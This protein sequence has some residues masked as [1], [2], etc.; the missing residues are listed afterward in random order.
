MSLTIRANAQNLE[1][2]KAEKEGSAGNKKTINAANLN[3][4]SGKEDAIEAK[5]NSA[6]KQAMKLISD[7][8]GRD[9]KTS[10]EIKNMQQM[11]A[12]KVAEL[13]EWKSK[14]KDI[15]SNKE[16]LREESGVELESR[17]QKDLELLEKYQNNINGSSFDSFSEEEVER[18]KELQNTPLTE[19]QK[20]ALKLNDMKGSVN[21]EV[22][23]AEREIATITKAITGAKIDKLKSQ[24]MIQAKDGAEEILD[25]AGKDIIG[26]LIEE[27]KENIDEA[28]E[29]AEQEEIEEK[30]E[31]EEILKDEQEVQKLEVEA[32]VD[33]QS[34]DHV[35]EAQKKI[36]QIINNNKLIN[37]DI[38]GI[39]IDLNF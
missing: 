21:M 13:Q 36:Q 1:T 23:M 6:R 27:G 8:W 33:K 7:A 34:V 4:A 10:D 37:E 30:D 29:E 32:S 25:A 3:F 9:E 15:D 20:K 5:K 39:E 16:L 14:I 2:Y 24:D 28:Q 18:L 22:Q 31:Q 11:K 35:E 38:K 19:Y 26:M 12:D 17:E